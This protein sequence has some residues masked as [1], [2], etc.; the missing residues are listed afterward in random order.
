[1]RNN[2]EK[3]SSRDSNKLRFSVGFRMNS[4]PDI[5]PIPGKRMNT[6]TIANMITYEI[7]RSTSRFFILSGIAYQKIDFDLS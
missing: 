7:R 1:M 3:F 6:K 2:N 5:V 4:C